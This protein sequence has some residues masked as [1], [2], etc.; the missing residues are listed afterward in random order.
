LATAYQSL[1]QK[2]KVLNIVDKIL[3]IDP[4]NVVAH[5]ILSSIYKYSK[6]NEETIS[7]ISKMEKILKNKFNRLFKKQEFLLLSEKHMKI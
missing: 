5:V 4:D 1:N 6:T 2:D 7:H 3:K